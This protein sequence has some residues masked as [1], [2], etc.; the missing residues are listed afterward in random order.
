MKKMMMVIGLV[1]VILVASFYYLGQKTEGTSVL[2]VQV[3][4]KGNI[5]DVNNLTVEDISAYLDPV[6][7]ISEPKG[8]FLITPGVTVIILQNK[9]SIGQWTSV[10]FNGTGV[11]NLTVGFAEY[12]VIGQNLTVV[13]RVLNEKSQNVA[14]VSKDIPAKYKD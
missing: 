7:R 1:I 5:D 9:R 3:T 10:P 4:V 12:P 11:Y 2:Q 6:N 14:V 8:N 13:A